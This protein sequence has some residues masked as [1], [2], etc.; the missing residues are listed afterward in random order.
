MASK[1]IKTEKTMIEAIK[2]SLDFAA[3]GGDGVAAPVAVLWTDA[4][5]QWKPALRALQAAIPYLYTL[6]SYNPEERSGPVI[7]L[8]CVIER[9][10]P[11]ISPPADSVPILYLPNVSRQ[12]LRAAGDC[13]RELLPLIELQYRGAVWHQRNGRDWTIDAFVTSEQGIGLDVAADPRTREAMYRSLP[14]LIAEPLVHL[15]PQRLHADNFDRLSVED[16]IRDVLTW[17]NDP[18]HFQK[19]ADETKWSSFRAVCRGNYKFDPE[20]DAPAIAA[21]GLLNGD[22]P[23]EEVW[24]RFT[25]SPHLYPAL[26]VVM[27]QAQARDLLAR[28]DRN[29]AVNDRE[30]AALRKAL[31]AAAGK[32]H[33]EA[34]SA[35][36]E[37]E[38]QHGVRRSWVWS[39]VDRAPLAIALESLAD[40]A[41]RADKP[42]SAPTIDEMIKIYAQG[43][44]EVDR[45]ALEALLNVRAPADVELIGKVVKALYADWLD[46]TAR[47]FQ[48]HVASKETDFR[49]LAKPVEAEQGACVLFADGL[50]FDVGGMLQ[51]ELEARS[52]KVRVSYRVAPLPTVT[53]TGKPWASPAHKLFEGPAS[54]EDFSPII[55]SSK[56]PVNAERLRKAMESQGVDVIEGGQVRMASNIAKGGWTEI[57]EIDE[58]GHKLNARLVDQIAREIDA[59]ADR[60]M[61]LLNAGWARVRIVTDHG[62][63]LLPGDLPKI[64]M[65][66]SLVVKK[67]HRAAAVKGESSVKLPTYPWHWNPQVV[68]VS[69]PG[70]GVFYADIEYAHGGVTLQ[71][72]VVPDIIVELGHRDHSAEIVKVEWK[73]MRCRVTVKTEAKGLR[74]DLRL[75]RNDPKSIAAAAK[76]V[77]ENG[78]VALIVNDDSHEG[79]GAVLVVLDPAD[80]VVHFFATTVGEAS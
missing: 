46:L 7:W 59:I 57:G 52:A 2:A 50:R 73:G 38:R 1:I 33:H 23:F 30:E 18:T 24:K 77:P 71:E 43:G 76:T 63:L 11:E 70:I 3:R 25:E 79:S 17:M 28:S 61:D 13:P 9:V 29:P 40:L 74:V 31:A 49:A 55:S 78:E 12:E 47:N 68:V 20:S 48:K 4:D 53:A 66:P 39:S 27:G 34:C 45:A 36:I 69:P 60:V 42:I 75:K 32:P 14:V 41:K 62:W 64:E 35:I 37:L 26:Y 6:G 10:L 8:K 58:L 22:G 5:G 51:E 80:K 16:P 67:G 15:R 54:T 65:P 56:Q 19:T 21:A 72:C 44:W